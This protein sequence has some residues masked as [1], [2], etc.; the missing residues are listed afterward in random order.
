MFQNTKII[1]REVEQASLSNVLFLV[2]SFCFSCTH[3]GSRSSR[4]AAPSEPNTKNSADKQ[5]EHMWPMKSRQELTQNDMMPHVCGIF[6]TP[7]VLFNYQLPTYD[8]KTIVTR[9]KLQRC[10]MSNQ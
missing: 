10:F 3:Q 9:H 8:D 5:K 2:L 1:C 6:C 4:W 7:A